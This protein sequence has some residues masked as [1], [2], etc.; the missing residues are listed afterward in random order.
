VEA[1]VPETL[2]VARSRYDVPT[3]VERVSAALAQRGVRL[4]A[5]IDHAAGAREAGLAL[6][7][8]VV[9]VFGNAAVGTALMQADPRAGLDLPLRLLVWSDS[10]STSVAFRDPHALA[11]EFDLAGRAAVLD[12]LRGL[13]DH[14][15]A[16]V[17]DDGAGAEGSA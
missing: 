2:I 11:V 3:T 4:F 17:A 10:G 5:V 13:L 1:A 7:D 9:L 12:G 16:E 15:V 6:A 8:E 14:L